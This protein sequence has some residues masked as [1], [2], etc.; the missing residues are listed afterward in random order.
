MPG[1]GSAVDER[2]GKTVAG[3]Y[4]LVRVLGSGGMGTVY[5]ARNAVFGKRVALKLIDAR[6]DPTGELAER[7][8][9]EARAAARI[10]SDSIVQV[11]DVGDDPEHGIFLVME[12]L[13]GEG[14][15]ARVALG[16]MDPQMA[17]FVAHRVA[18]VLARAHAA[19]IV[20]RDL[21]PANVFIVTREDGSTNVKLLDFG[22]AKVF[23]KGVT[24]L[25]QLGSIVGTPQYMSPEQARGVDDLDGRTDLWALGCI[26]Y[27]CLAG[28]PVYP[29]LGNPHHT[30]LHVVE[31]PPTPLATVAPWVHPVLVSLV[32]S[33]LVVDRDKRMRDAVTLVRHLEHAAPFVDG[34]ISQ[35]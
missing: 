24:R 12:Y 4:L 32:D 35:T 20:H 19:G 6:N 15:D 30:L 10:E 1:M 33:L 8:R 34:R 17:V 9:R 21:K 29:D 3:K 22:L 2:I 31:N 7:M 18:K 11:F 25:T 13:L 23:E 27:E 14:L 26:L 28:R 5:E 16:V